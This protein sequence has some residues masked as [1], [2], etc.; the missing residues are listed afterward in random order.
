[1]HC[2][3]RIGNIATLHLE[4]VGSFS[5]RGSEQRDAPQ[6]SLTS[7]CVHPPGWTLLPAER[8][9]ISAK[10]E[11]Y[12][13]HAE[14]AACS[15]QQCQSTKKNRF[16]L[17]FLWSWVWLTLRLSCMD[18]FFFSFVVVITCTF[19]AEHKFPHCLCSI[20]HL[21]CPNRGKNISKKDRV[22][23]KRVWILGGL[24]KKHPWRAFFCEAFSLMHRAWNL[25][26]TKPNSICKVTLSHWWKVW[27]WKP[28]RITL[29]ICKQAQFKLSQVRSEL[30]QNIYGFIWHLNIVENSTRN[31][32][33]VAF[34]A[35]TAR[36][37]KIAMDILCFHLNSPE[38]SEKT[39]RLSFKRT[40]IVHPATGFSWVECKGQEKDWQSMA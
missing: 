16:K 11:G 14:E 17:I 13:W 31:I 19:T 39:L 34:A 4:G 6:P 1:M 26:S 30:F 5:M 2:H 37:P 32:V 18:D 3:Q 27:S 10:A 24:L 9:Q 22:K 8:F 20:T 38:T 29:L 33:L 35:E 21:L 28:W 12:V 7:I 36:K 23:V 25:M 40:N 15:S